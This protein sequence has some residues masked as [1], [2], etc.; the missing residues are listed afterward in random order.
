MTTFRDGDAFPLPEIKQ[1]QPTREEL[2]AE[3][4]RLKTEWQSCSSSSDSE[5]AYAKRLEDQIVRL[6]ARVG[7]M[8]D[9]GQSA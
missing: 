2:I 7:E 3:I 9:P 6:E 1:N 4:A 5:I 8:N